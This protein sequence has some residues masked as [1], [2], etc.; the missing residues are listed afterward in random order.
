MM[1]LSYKQIG[2]SMKKLF[3]IVL[4]VAIGMFF[5]DATLFDLAGLDNGTAYAHGKGKGK[6]KG[7]GHGYDDGEGKGPGRGK[8]RGHRGPSTPPTPGPTPEPSPSAPEARGAVKGEADA[9][10]VYGCDTSWER[11]TYPECYGLPY[12]LF[13]QNEHTGNVAIPVVRYGFG[14]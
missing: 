12:Y 9:S 6:D 7:K 4:A 13:L 8:G 2:G 10:M 3:I 1:M 5:I 14:Y 11:A